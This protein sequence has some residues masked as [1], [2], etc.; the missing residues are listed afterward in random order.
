ML[1]RVR[2]SISPPLTT[3]ITD[4]SLVLNYHWAIGGNGGGSLA[5]PKTGAPSQAFDKTNTTAPYTARRLPC[6]HRNR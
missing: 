1:S 4:S 6:Y 5:D 3:P 2:S